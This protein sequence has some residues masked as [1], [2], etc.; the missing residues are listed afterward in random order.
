MEGMQCMCACILNSGLH[1]CCL[2][3]S[4]GIWRG[5]TGVVAK[6]KIRIN[7]ANFEVAIKEKYS[8]DLLGWPEGVPFQSPTAITSVEHLQTLRDALKEGAC[9]W[10]YMTRQ[11]HVQYQDQLAQWWNAGEVVGKARKRCSDMGR[12]WCHTESSKGKTSKSTALID[13]S[14]EESDEDNMWS[15]VSLHLSSFET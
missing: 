8:I 2:T 9:H 10:A 15:F 1:A 7:F 5:R 3:R 4:N 13:S 6:K 12:K 14:D 11:Q